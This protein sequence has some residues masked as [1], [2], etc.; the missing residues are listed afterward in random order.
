M[1]L[2]NCN[3]KIAHAF[4][5]LWNSKYIK[6]KSKMEKRLSARTQ[7]EPNKLQ[8]LFPLKIDDS[9]KRIFHTHCC[10]LTGNTILDI[11]AQYR[12][13]SPGEQ[14]PCSLREILGEPAVGLD[15]RGSCRASSAVRL[16]LTKP[17]HMIC[18]NNNYVHTNNQTNPSPSPIP[19]I[20]Q[21]C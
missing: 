1:I 7:Y 8:I 5:T 9:D 17:T 12:P 20:H 14:E 4:T 18:Y 13:C 3:C 19:T 6:S 15:V 10:P 2:E 21:L 11:Q 16:P